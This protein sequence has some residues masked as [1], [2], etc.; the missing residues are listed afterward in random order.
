MIESFAA[1]LLPSAARSG[2]GAGVSSSPGEVSLFQD[3]GVLVTS[4][5]VV[6]GGR[7]QAL[8]DVERVEAVRRSPRLE[9]VLFALVLGAV[10]ALP[11]HPLLVAVEAALAE[12]ALVLAGSVIFGSIARLLMAEDSYHVVLHTRHG[13]WRLLSSQEPAHTTRLAGVIHEAATTARRRR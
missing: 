13:A 2:R 12:A 1:R 6:A 8:E 5:R 11:A 7:S 9:P 3:G 4:E 10:V